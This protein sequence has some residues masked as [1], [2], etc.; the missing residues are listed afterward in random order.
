MA[1]SSAIA[2]SVDVVELFASLASLQSASGEERLVADRVIAFARGLGLEVVEDDS[3][4]R[5]HGSAGNL[6]IRLAPTL[7]GGVPIV[8]CAHL[9][10]VPVQRE[11][12]VVRDGAVVRSDGSTI[13]GADNKA[14]V[15]VMLVAMR[16]LIEEAR[17]HAG[18]ELL[19]TTMEELGC[20]GAR[21]FDTS[22]LTA[23]VGFVYD[24]ADDIGVYVRSAPCGFLVELLFKGRAAHAGLAPSEGRSAIQAAAHAI[25]RI[26]TGQLDGGATVNVGVI[27]GGTAHNVVP[28]ECSI[29]VDIRA[30]TYETANLLAQEIVGIASSSATQGGCKLDVDVQEKY[31]DYAFV[32][33]EQVVQIARTALS[34]CGVAAEGVDANGGADASIFNARGLSLINLANGMAQI[35]TT[36][37]HIRIADLEKML[38]VTLALVEVAADENPVG[39]P[40]RLQ[41]RSKARARSTEG[42][43]TNSEPGIRG[44]W[45]GQPERTVSSQAA[46][47][48]VP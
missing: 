6:L 24:H 34:Q 15:A 5:L 16:I 33:D 1:K 43:A 38:D 23:R 4:S 46:A 40:A 37:E 48:R 22:A 20:R 26:K 2:S 9:D 42:K 27:R 41:G 45:P 29:T 8:F 11:I 47:E 14:A 36:D 21:E 7:S 10:T 44:E 3:A 12:R 35:H 25:T 31:R 17:D 30:R 32:G 28:A 19:F 18:V 39:G 13:L